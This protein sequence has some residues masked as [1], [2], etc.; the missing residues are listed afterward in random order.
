MRLS[1]LGMAV[2]AALSGAV[3]AANAETP[4]NSAPICAVVVDRGGTP[5]CEF[6]TRE[7]CMLSISGIGGLCI[8]NPSYHPG[9][10]LGPAGSRAAAR[11]GQR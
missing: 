10:A 9:L 3:A 2:L 5:R 4:Y 11:R 7:Q 1:F 8:Q 6:D